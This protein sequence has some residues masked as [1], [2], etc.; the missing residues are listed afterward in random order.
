MVWKKYESV[1]PIPW[2]WI[3]IGKYQ[4]EKNAIHRSIFCAHSAKTDALPIWWINAFVRVQM[5]N[6]GSAF[7][8]TLSLSRRLMFFSI[9][10]DVHI[11]Y[12]TIHVHFVVNRNQAT[13]LK[14]NTHHTYTILPPDGCRCCSRRCYRCRVCLPWLPGMCMNGWTTRLYEWIFRSQFCVN[15]N[16]CE[17]VKPRVGAMFLFLKSEIEWHEHP[18]Q[19]SNIHAHSHMQTQ[20]SE[21][22]RYIRQYVC[23][24]NHSYPW[25]CCAPVYP[26]AC[27]T[28]SLFHWF[29]LVYLFIHHISSFCRSFFH[30]FSV[31]LL[32]FRFH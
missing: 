7:S 30:S 27:S 3:E 26:S 19:A 31:C 12:Y 17:A 8:I 9:H 18:Q 20:S 10:V 32:V 23:G 6:I 4:C 22:I 13:I 16:V 21:Y 1:R 2:K 5:Y 14:A 29:S 11:L 25:L 15:W 28:L 24:W